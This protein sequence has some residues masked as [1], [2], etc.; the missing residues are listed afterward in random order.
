MA[1]RDSDSVTMPHRHKSSARARHP[2]PRSISSPVRPSSPLRRRAVP[3]R[4]RATE[5]RLAARV[6]SAS[7][8]SCSSVARR[9]REAANSPQPPV[10][11]STG[12][13]AQAGGWDA[14][15]ATISLLSLSAGC[16]SAPLRQWTASPSTRGGRTARLSAARRSV[17][18]SSSSLHGAAPS[19][20]SPSPHCLSPTGAPP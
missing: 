13:P 6:T 14:G 4:G 10:P 16:P 9:G 11:P 7:F 12:A 15:G 8:C 17:V 20:S 18:G 3:N 19:S 1:E 5:L 2:P